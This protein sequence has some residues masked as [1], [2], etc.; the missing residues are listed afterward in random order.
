MQNIINKIFEFQSL[1]K[2]KVIS[3]NTKIS[4]FKKINYVCFGI[5]IIYGIF[6]INLEFNEYVKNFLFLIICIV[7]L[8]SIFL[9]RMENM[10]SSIKEFLETSVF[11]TLIL[12]IF[13]YWRLSKY[14][15]DRYWLYVIIIITFTLIWS[16]L[17]T[18]SNPKVGTISNAII[19]VVLGI[20]LQANSFIWSIF[21][22]DKINLGFDISY[23]GLNFSEYEFIEISINT[24]LFP[25][26]VMVTVGA[27]ACAYK[28]YW[29]EDR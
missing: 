22:L 9:S 7:N 24:L 13:I 5:F 17:S 19:A 14:I 23:V 4:L 21:E 2:D 26:F 28:E 1:I 10:C 3:D 12:C 29:L 15:K 20:A 18:L 8:I 27:L 6:I 25:F 11:T 16:F